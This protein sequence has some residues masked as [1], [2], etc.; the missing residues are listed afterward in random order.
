MMCLILSTFLHSVML[1]CRLER[2][3][4]CFLSRSPLLPLVLLP[5][6]SPFLSPSVS[7]C[8]H[9]LFRPVNSTLLKQDCFAAQ[10]GPCVS[11]PLHNS[12][13]ELSSH[14]KQGGE[15]PAAPR[16]SQDKKHA[17]KTWLFT[18]RFILFLLQGTATDALWEFTLVKVS[19]APRG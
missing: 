11:R 1:F 5:S 7:L 13:C 12:A 15:I 6:L 9:G 2:A 16:V 4:L 19:I 8:A 18:C 3:S 14:P 10:I 17:C